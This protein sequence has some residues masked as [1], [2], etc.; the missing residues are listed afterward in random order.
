MKSKSYSKRLAMTALGALF[1][2]PVFAA[3]NYP[4]GDI[5]YREAAALPDSIIDPVSG[6]DVRDN[7]DSTLMRNDVGV[8]DV[9]GANGI[10]THNGNDPRDNRDSTILRSDVPHDQTNM[11]QS[12]SQW[13]GSGG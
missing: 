8:V 1:A 6:N 12:A 4:Q 3:D 13:P 5:Q 11:Q 2:I 9:P 7:R 10:D